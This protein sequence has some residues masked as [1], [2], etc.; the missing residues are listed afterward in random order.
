LTLGVGPKTIMRPTQ[1]LRG[2][3]TGRHTLQNLGW[4]SFCLYSNDDP[5]TNPDLE[6][7]Q[8]GSDCSM[9]HTMSVDSP[10]TSSAVQQGVDYTMDQTMSAADSP[11]AST[12]AI[13]VF[14]L[15]ADTSARLSL[16]SVPD[17]DCGGNT[18][19][20]NYLQSVLRDPD[21]HILVGKL[22]GRDEVCSLFAYQATGRSKCD[23]TATLW[24]TRGEERCKGLAT[25]L[26]QVSIE[27][28]LNEDSF[29]FFGNKCFQ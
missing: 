1:T 15:G 3:C 11:Q 14:R 27:P 26:L 21:N 25:S 2:I 20:Y 12:P 8:H 18:V 29:I 17:W 13:D 10:Q 6:L 7:F 24:W 22:G 16:I 4:L 23:M 19:P 5:K 9:G 28:L